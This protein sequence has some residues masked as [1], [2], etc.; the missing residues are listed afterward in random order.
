MTEKKSSE[1]VGLKGT[2]IQTLHTSFNWYVG[3]YTASVSI[4]ASDIKAVNN[5]S[6]H[7][8]Q[9]VD[10]YS[11]Q[12]YIDHLFTFRGSDADTECWTAKMRYYRNGKT[13]AITFSRSS[14]VYI[15]IFEGSATV[16]FDTLPAVNAKCVVG[17]ATNGSERIVC[18]LPSFTIPEEDFEVFFT[19]TYGKIC[20]DKEARPSVYL[21]DGGSELR[22]AYEDLFLGGKESDFSF[23]IGK[24]KIPAHK[25][26][27]VTRVPYFDKM[28]ASGMVESQTNSISIKDSDAASFRD[29][30]RYIY[31]AKLP[32]KLEEKSFQILPLADK[33]DLQSLKDACI[34]CMDVCLTKDNVCDTL[35]IADLYRCDALKKKCLKS[36]NE[37]RASLDSKVF[38]QLQAYP[39]LMVELIKTN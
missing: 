32:E 7:R 13:L 33:Y 10:A 16:T 3:K 1:D 5:L 37:W 11:G 22:S 25:A 26:I 19:V 36:L 38:E 21:Q 6:N 23:V 18:T 31:C 34:H 8:A 29:V 27:L 9:A 28:L 4:K 15:E 35:I 14:D 20:R 30:L 17:N 24:E 2:P 39:A 12:T